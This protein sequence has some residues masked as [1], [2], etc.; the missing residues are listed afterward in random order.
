MSTMERFENPNRPYGLYFLIGFVL[1]V[2]GWG[3][4]V[5]PFRDLTLD[6][7]VAA[8]AVVMLSPLVVGAAYGA[9]VF[10]FG[11]DEKLPLGRALK[12]GL[13]GRP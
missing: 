13:P 4:V 2:V 9:R 8:R 11:R 6:W 3:L 12:R 5:T 7:P 10:T 1:G